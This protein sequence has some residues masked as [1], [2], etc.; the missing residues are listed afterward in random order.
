MFLPGGSAKLSLPV[1]EQL[2]LY[3]PKITLGPLKAT[4][5]LMWPLVKMSLTPLLYSKDELEDLIGICWALERGLH[6]VSWG[7]KSVRT[8]PSTLPHCPPGC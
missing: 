4:A 6:S 2:H 8:E 5:R 7:E 3:G 1:M